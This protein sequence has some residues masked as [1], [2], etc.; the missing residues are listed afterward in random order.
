MCSRRILNCIAAKLLSSDGKMKRLNQAGK[1]FLAYLI[2]SDLE[3][4]PRGPF[5]K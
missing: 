3:H 2:F 4:L 5:S 1:A